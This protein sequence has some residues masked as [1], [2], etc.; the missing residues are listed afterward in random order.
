MAERTRASRRS[1]L[2]SRAG[3]A[4]CRRRHVRCDENRPL[5]S[6]TRWLFTCAMLTMYSQN[7]KR[8][9]LRCGYSTELLPCKAT[10]YDEE[11]ETS[12]L[13]SSPEAISFG[14]PCHVNNEVEV[15]RATGNVP[16]PMQRLG[17]LSSVTCLDLSPMDARMIHHITTF[18]GRLAEAGALEYAFALTSFP[19]FI[20]VALGHDCTKEAMLALAA[21]HLRMVAR[22]DQ[23]DAIAKKYLTRARRSFYAS[24]QGLTKDNADAALASSLMLGWAEVDRYRFCA[25]RM[26]LCTDSL[27]DQRT[28]M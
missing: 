24:V 25:R 26:T 11:A 21:H 7:C 19:L 14:W 4:T 3:C 16:S 22:D 8:L 28:Q 27:E 13:S 17:D 9:S 20:Q 1:H 23:S 6:V 12:P 18:T 10:E 2:K 15:W 5:W